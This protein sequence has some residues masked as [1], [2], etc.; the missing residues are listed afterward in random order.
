MFYSYDKINFDTPIIMWNVYF[1]DMFSYERLIYVHEYFVSRSRQ[2]LAKC[3]LIS[4]R[5]K[6]SIYV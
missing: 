4:I 2:Q 1:I 6:Y 5:P 3:K